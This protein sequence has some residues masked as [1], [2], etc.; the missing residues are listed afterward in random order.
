[1]ASSAHDVYAR[2]IALLLK[3]PRDPRGEASPAHALSARILGNFGYKPADSPIVGVALHMN[4]KGTFEVFLFL[5]TSIDGIAGSVADFLQAGEV[6]I[7]DL[8]TG[9]IR[10]TSRP[11]I[12][13]ESLG[14]GASGGESGTFGA[15]V[16]DAAG[17]ELLLTC[18]HVVA[19]ANAGVIGTSVIWQPSAN[20]GG[21][22][23][24]RIGILHDIELLAIGGTVANDFDAA[25][26]EPDASHFAKAGVKVLGS[27]AGTASGTGYRTSV[28]KYGW[29]TSRTDGTFLYRTSFIQHYPGVGDALFVDQLGIVGTQGAFSDGGDSGAVVVNTSQEVCGLLFADAPDIS[30]SFASPIQPVLT[31]F[32]I[33]FV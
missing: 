12:G 26:V 6:P 30:M 33:G 27:L 25:V 9:R 18:N 11:A 1:M 13:G 16:K 14:E 5:A 4:E 20:D 7:H 29:K 28:R 23:A 21:T 19:Q 10:P 22:S 8:V 2:A 24:D 3:G 17:T 31:R 15:L 32:G